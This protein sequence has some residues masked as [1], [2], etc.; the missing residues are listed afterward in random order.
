MAHHWRERQR[1]EDNGCWSPLSGIG[2]LAET[3][4]GCIVFGIIIAI[5][6]GGL[7]WYFWS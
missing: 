5:V 7:A 4:W 6:G 3:A 2:A 1:T